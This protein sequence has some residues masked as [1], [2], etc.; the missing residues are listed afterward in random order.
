M[1]R[2]YPVTYAMSVDLLKEEMIE[3][4]HII[5]FEKDIFQIIFAVNRRKNSFIKTCR[6]VYFEVV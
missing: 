5:V 4:R 6:V 2:N 3:E 1:V